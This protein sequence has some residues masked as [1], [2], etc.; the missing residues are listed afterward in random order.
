M[1]YVIISENLLTLAKNIVFNDFNEGF[2]LINVFHHFLLTCIN[3]EIM[4][5]KFNAL[6]N[7]TDT[8]YD[9]NETINVNDLKLFEQ[10][11][12]ENHETFAKIRNFYLQD[13]HYQGFPKLVEIMIP[14]LLQCEYLFLTESFNEE[15][16]KD[17]EFVDENDDEIKK[18]YFEM[19]NNKLD[20]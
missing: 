2:K 6:L 18:Y 5:L 10:I 12:I 8:I 4:I 9:M 1:S 13:L 7:N 20:N 15:T 3:N 19:L 11:Q 14:K 17:F 16:T